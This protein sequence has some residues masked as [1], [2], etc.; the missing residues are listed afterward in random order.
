MKNNAPN[1]IKSEYVNE[2]DWYRFDIDTLC[3]K[4]GTDKE[5]GL[6]DRAVKEKR[7]E[8]GKNDIFPS[9]EEEKDNA[10]KTAF[11]VLS[12]L[13]IICFVLAGFLLNNRTSAAAVALTVAGYLGV[14]VMFF[15]S[16]RNVSRLS[17]YSVPNVRVIR[18]G[19]MYRVSQI[20]IVQGDLIYLCEGDLVPCDGRLVSSNGLK[21]LE[22]NI[23]GGDG[24]KDAE[25]VERLNGLDTSMQKNMVFAR[26]AVA[27]G[28]C[29]MIACDTGSH[30]LP[31]RRGIK[32]KAAGSAALDVF[33]KVSK[34]SRIYAVSCSVVLFAVTALSYMRVGE[35]E[36]FNT[37]LLLLSVAASSYCEL[38]CAFAYVAVAHGISPA[39]EKKDAYNTGII[40]K[41]LSAVKRLRELSCLMVPKSAGICERRIVA[42]KI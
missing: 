14:L 10:P 22:K 21:V 3:R 33:T 1:D 39:K 24:V 7:A 5:N 26:S 32:A 20:G 41:N 23:S 36:I 25:F 38:L 2:A 8:Q 42:E 17:L 34:L 30:S 16:K 13:L 15:I 11:S 6:S 27:S 12:V 35:G 9:A 40:I 4:L 19:K 37:F 28:S 31:V 18:G 29:F